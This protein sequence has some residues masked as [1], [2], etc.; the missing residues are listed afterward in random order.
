MHQD[1]GSP[2]VPKRLLRDPRKGIGPANGGDTA[3]FRLEL[4]GK[5]QTLVTAPGQQIAGKVRLVQPL[6]NHYFVAGVEVVK[7]RPW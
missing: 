3:P 4:G 1:V 7:M 2:P 5:A 6:L